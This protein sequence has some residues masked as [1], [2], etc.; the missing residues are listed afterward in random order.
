MH[1]DTLVKWKDLTKGNKNGKRRKQKKRR[2]DKKQK[3]SNLI[4]RRKV[5]PS[6]AAAEKNLKVVTMSLVF[7]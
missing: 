3:N 4:Y 1:Y 2:K 6:L 5:L 7:V